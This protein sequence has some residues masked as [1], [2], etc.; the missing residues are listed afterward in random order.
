MYSNL[1]E[2]YKKALQKA[3]KI[4]LRSLHLIEVLKAFTNENSESE[5]EDEDE[6]LDEESSRSDKENI[7][8]F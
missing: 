4:K 1:H 2:T 8:M 7:N 3:L 6:E 5:N